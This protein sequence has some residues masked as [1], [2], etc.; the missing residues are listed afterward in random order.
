MAFPATTTTTT[1]AKRDAIVLQA[2]RGFASAPNSPRVFLQS[3]TTNVNK[4][5]DVMQLIRHADKAAAVGSSSPGTNV[6]SM[7][8]RICSLFPT[9]REYDVRELL[10]K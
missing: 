6:E 4:R 10:I 2:S 9:A 7:L 8:Q 5:S 3:G 1:H